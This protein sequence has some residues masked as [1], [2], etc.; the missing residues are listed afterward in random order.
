MEIAKF[1]NNLYYSKSNLVNSHYSIYLSFA[2]KILEYNY[3]P[4]IKN[5]ILFKKNKS[6]YYLI[7]FLFPS[8]TKYKSNGLVKKLQFK[9]N[10]SNLNQNLLP[11][12]PI[13]NKANFSFFK[14]SKKSLSNQSNIIYQ[15][16]DGKGTIFYNTY[17]WLNYDKNFNLINVKFDCDCSYFHFGGCRFNLSKYNKTLFKTN[18]P[19]NNVDT[20]CKHIYLLTIL[21]KKEMFYEKLKETLKVL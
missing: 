14:Y 20:I 8:I 7:N 15:I 1:L 3:L 11:K 6:N 21:L 18:I 12:N 13:L 19:S 4:N 10:Y 2:E 17:L 16:A 9:I 5:P